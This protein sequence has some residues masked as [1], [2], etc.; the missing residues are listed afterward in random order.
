MPK[1]LTLFSDDKLRE[2]LLESTEIIDSLFERLHKKDL[3]IL[4]Q[5]DTIDVLQ[6]KC[7]RY[8]RILFAEPEGAEVSD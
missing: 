5:Q 2:L 8:D 1:D 4:T 6:E 3:M 7:E